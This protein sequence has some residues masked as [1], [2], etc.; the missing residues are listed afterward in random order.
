MK[1]RLYTRSGVTLMLG[2]V[3]GVSLRELR[4]HLALGEVCAEPV[5]APAREAESRFAHEEP[6]FRDHRDLK[7]WEDATHVARS[8]EPAADPVTAGSGGGAGSSGGGSRG[9]KPKP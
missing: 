5:E 8:P 3:E 1:T 9:G 6:T 4:R 7:H 2:D